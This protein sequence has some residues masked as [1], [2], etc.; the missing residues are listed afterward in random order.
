MDQYDFVGRTDAAGR[1][2]IPTVPQGAFVVRVSRP[3][4]ALGLF[5]DVAGSLASP[6]EV[7]PVEAVVPPV[8]TVQVQVNSTTGL[9][10]GGAGIASD[11]R[12]A[13]YFESVWGDADAN[14]RLTIPSV[15]GDRIITVQAFSQANRYDYRQA[16]AR[17]TT[18]GET[19]TVTIVLG[20]VGS[21]VGQVTYRDGAP[22]AGVSLT[23]R[24]ESPSF[25]AGVTSDAAGRY[26]IDSV[27]PGPF[28]ITAADYYATRAAGAFEGVVAAHDDVVSGDIVLDRL[29]PPA[30][31]SDANG[32]RYRINA[33]AT[34]GDFTL[35][36]AYLSSS[37]LQVTQYQGFTGDFAAGTELNGRQLSVG[38][39]GGGGRIRETPVG[40]LYVTRKV[41]VPASGY[42]ARYLEILENR[43]P[44]P[45]TVDVQ[46]R[47]R[48]WAG[49]IAATSGGSATLTSS[50]QWFVTSG[51]ASQPLAAAEV[52]AGA[53]KTPSFAE[54]QG[55]G[56][57]LSATVRWAGVTVNPGERAIFMHFTSQQGDQAAAVAT[58]DRLVQLPLEA[59]V[60][61]TPA[62]AADI[63]NFTVPPDLSSSAPPLL[64][65]RGRV[66]ASDRT[67]PVAGAAVLVTGSLTPIFKPTVTVMTDSEGR[68]A[69]D[70]LAAGPFTVQARYA[71]AGIATAVA[72]GSVTAGST[73]AVQD[74]VFEST[75]ALTGT[76][77]LAAGTPAG[78][79]TVTVTGGDPAFS[80]SLATASDGSYRFAALPAGTFAISATVSGRSSIASSANVVEGQTVVADLRLPASATLRLR[81]LRADGSPQ[82]SAYAYVTDAGG[83]RFAGYVDADGVLLISGVAEGAFTVQVEGD[84]ST[85]LSGSVTAADD[86]GI[87]DL[88]VQ[89][90]AASVSGHVTAADGQT[91]VPSAYL[92]LIDGATGA[93]A[94]ATFAD[95]TGYYEFAD[96]VLAGGTS[97]A[98]VAH[99]P[100]SFALTVQSGPLTAGAPVVV[101]LSFPFTSVHG[102]VVQADGVTPVAYGNVT[103]GQPGPDGQ[104][105]TLYGNVDRF[106]DYS[107]FGVTTGPFEVIVVDRYSNMTGFASGVVPSLA[108]SPTADVTLGPT[109]QVVGVVR[110]AD[111]QPVPYADVALS[112]NALGVNEYRYVTAGPDGSYGF[113]QSPVGAV[114]VQGCGSVATT[115]ACA[116]RT[117]AIVAAGDTVTLNLQ[118][119]AFG[120]VSGVVLADDGIT[121]VAGAY[122]QI[123]S[124]ETGPLGSSRSYTT[125]DA[126]GAYAFADVVSGPVAVRAYAPSTYGL[127]GG[128]AVTLAPGASLQVNLPS[129]A[130]IDPCAY[131]ILSGTDGFL[132]GLGCDG[133]IAGGGAVDGHLG[134]SYGRFGQIMRING[135][136]AGELAPGQPQLAGRQLSYGAQAQAGVVTTRQVYV[137]TA[138]GFARFLDTVT[139]PTAAAITLEVQI[140]TVLPGIASVLIDPASTGQ[141]YAVTVSAPVISGG[142]TQSSAVLAHVLGGAGAAV[143]AT[144]AHFQHLLGSSVLALRGDGG[145]GAVCIPDALRGA[146]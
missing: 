1:L 77:R 120:S 37:A 43:S 87:I 18:E 23:L 51:S 114:S 79:G 112:S 146:A 25:G 109:G 73:P 81:V 78:P 61:L 70:T 105:V 39:Y 143:G 32:Y 65:V 6:G 134:V 121:P 49:G 123:A 103:V 130:T 133:G 138:G 14:G 124:G 126:S 102:H 127:L 86:G 83:Y 24:S 82:S 106:G 95:A 29:L 74:L 97:F 21:V 3:D 111:G 48:F 41:Y 68:Y 104:V 101:N 88:L 117:G 20:A 52:L 139:N 119:R 40:G 115:Y 54:S 113:P 145:T 7:V 99:A 100:A 137:P 142:T 94:D 13:G 67:T 92:Q 98:I 75:G 19:V 9:P 22:A 66:L 128:A 85:S 116:A 11:A 129:G 144:A 8:G 47:P 60:G 110:G 31:L 76:V 71:P 141:Q 118:V 26:R 136:A 42:F 64:Q 140:E 44:A 4:G 91:P 135:T 17:V 58:A 10:V 93:A 50:D 80:L 53:G 132:Y 63:R 36:Q 45:V 2:T 5:V 89:A 96:V 72:T 12:Y 35:D 107:I 46:L 131:P 62:D 90:A 38:N 15:P 16:A 59:L 34:L 84:R 33:D 108:A 30:T 122:V 56:F 28:R 55:G 57:D 69:V 27:P 125:T